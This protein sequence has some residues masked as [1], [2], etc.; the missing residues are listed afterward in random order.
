MLR[1]TEQLALFTCCGTHDKT[2]KPKITLQVIVL[3]THGKFVNGF[4]FHFE[5]C[6]KICLW[7]PK[8]ADANISTYPVQ[9]LTSLF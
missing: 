7:N 9:C 8:T 1:N 6:F 2:N 4:H 5:N 3:G